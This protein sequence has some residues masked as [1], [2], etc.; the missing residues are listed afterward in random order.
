MSYKKILRQCGFFVFVVGCIA[1]KYAHCQS[2]QDDDPMFMKCEKQWWCAMIAQPLS[3][4][5]ESYSGKAIEIAESPRLLITIPADPV[6][7]L[8][9]DHILFVSYKDAGL[10]TFEVSSESLFQGLF[11]SL[12]KG[13]RFTMLDIA[14]ILF[15]KTSEDREPEETA[16]LLLWRFA[17]NLKSMFFSEK[18]KILTAKKGPVT[19]Y[20]WQSPDGEKTAVF[21]NDENPNAFLKMVGKGMS[22]DAFKKV[23]AGVREKKK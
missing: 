15:T 2:L 7:I 4:W 23:I 12:M 13:T 16:D 19:C 21:V 1:P 14:T 8:H 11:P 9:S 6:R 22:F 17:I 5:P 20:Y 18:T 3:P 10:I